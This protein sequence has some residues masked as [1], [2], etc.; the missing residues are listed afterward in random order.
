MTID[1]I[2]S[3]LG[4]K[5]DYLLNHKCSKI[6]KDNIILPSNNYIDD[7][8]LYSNRNNKVLSSLSR[9]YNHGKLKNTGYLSILPI[10]QGIEHTAGAS[11][12]LNKKYFNPE[13]IVKLAIES[14]CNG[15][16]S[17]F[18]VL[19]IV[20]R[21]YAHK[22][23]FIVKINHNELITYPNKYDQILFG[24]IKS[25]WDL[26]AIAVGA[27]IYFGSKESSKQIIDVANAF[28][29]AHDLGM[30]TILWCYTRNDNFI[31]NGINYHNS[32]DISSQ[33]IHLGVTL[34]A[35][36]IKQKMP[37]NSFFSFKKLNF[38]KWNDEMYNMIGHHPIDMCRY[39]IINSYCGMCPVLNSGGNAI[40][41]KKDIYESLFAAI[42]NKRAG[43]SGLIMGRKAF[44]KDMSKGI[45]LINIVQDVYLNKDISI[46]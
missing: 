16:A 1:N 33:S 11:F 25:A 15:I 38:G 26:G 35:D 30:G 18:G 8:M 41:D 28:Q 22:I 46:A 27:T 10:D 3:I 6:T 20:S 13:N 5:S 34:Q 17:T 42:V 36:I 37:D 4:N 40:N 12:S 9:L 14:E 43:G 19:G 7:V 45:E 2:I 44:Q 23:P 39:Q 29:Y 24:T 31:N 32:A 21:K